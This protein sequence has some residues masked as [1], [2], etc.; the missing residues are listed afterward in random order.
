MSKKVYE[1]LVD[2]VGTGTFYVEAET[3]E[4]AYAMM[5]DTDI[6]PADLIDGLEVVHPSESDAIDD[7]YNWL[8][9]D[10]IIRKV[11]NDNE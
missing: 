2:V 1:V 11:D 3:A 8:S 10:D 6:E 7:A 4:E 5:C 9:N